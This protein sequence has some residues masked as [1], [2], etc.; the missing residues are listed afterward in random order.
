MAASIVVGMSV[1][2]TTG[3]QAVAYIVSSLG[4]PQVW[5][6]RRVAFAATRHAVAFLGSLLPALTYAL[7]PVGWHSGKAK[8]GD[9]EGCVKSRGKWGFGIFKHEC[10]YNA[11]AKECVSKSWWNK[12][13]LKGNGAYKWATD[14]N[15]CSLAAMR[16]MN[17]KHGKGGNEK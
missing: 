11:E 14:A 13:K 17:K 9:C 12:R 2:S 16:V 10:M 3:A 5:L 8:N 15:G 4:I 7:H 1:P 6:L